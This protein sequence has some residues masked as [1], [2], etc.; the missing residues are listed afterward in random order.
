M[1]GVLA[2][3]ASGETTVVTADDNISK[4]LED[5]VFSATGLKVQM[6]VEEFALEDIY[7]QYFRES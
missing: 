3:T 1:H 7:L 6:K 4:Q 2:I 5:V